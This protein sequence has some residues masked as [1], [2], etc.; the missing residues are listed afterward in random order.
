MRKHKQKL[1]PSIAE[2]RLLIPWSEAASRDR[3]SSTLF[4]AG[5]LHGVILLGVT[6][7]GAEA[8]PESGSTS[9]DV[10]LITDT[11]KLEQPATADMLAQQNMTGAGNIDEPMQLQTALSQTLD[12]A[13]LGAEQLGAERPQRV[14]TGSRQQRPTIVARSI[15]SA[16]AMP[17]HPDSEVSQAELQQQSLVGTSRAVEM[18][19]KPEA[20]TR[21]SDS[22]RRELVIGANTREARIA[23]YLSKW[24]NQIERIGTLNYPNVARTQGLNRFPTLEVAIES[25]GKL[26][27]VIIRQSSGV[28]GLDQAAINIVSLSAPFD[29]FPEFLRQE[30]DILRFA[31]EW[32]FTDG[33]A[34]SQL[35]PAEALDGDRR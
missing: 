12:A 26:H 11:K 16:L 8:P 34:Y 35:S 31:Y 9:F 32:R 30:Y 22:D 19:N 1:R 15:A 6:F 2:P 17:A 23:A 29:P 5:L 18:I 14:E 20:E 25:N 4:I 33:Y 3:L 28:R 27:E 13:A 21:I 24:K 7:T 10:V